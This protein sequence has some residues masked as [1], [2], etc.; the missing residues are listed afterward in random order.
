[1]KQDEN[2]KRKMD[3]EMIL[4]IVSAGIA[5]CSGCVGLYLYLTLKDD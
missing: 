4:I 5:I 2:D 1:M 3:S